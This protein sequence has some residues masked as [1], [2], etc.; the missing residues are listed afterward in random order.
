VF[1]EPCWGRTLEGLK[2]TFSSS[3]RPSTCIA[4][5]C[6]RG[7]GS[8]VAP[9]SVEK[10]GS[11]GRTRTYNPPVNSRASCMPPA[12]SKGAYSRRKASQ[13]LYLVGL[14]DHLAD[15]FP[16]LDGFTSRPFDSCSAAD[17]RSDETQ[18]PLRSLSQMERAIPHT[19]TKIH[20]ERAS[21]NAAWSFT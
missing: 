16:G 11:S 20:C 4:S 5:S 6:P 1:A 14:A 2:K 3:T 19:L 21:R 7:Q 9:L 15:K 17:R 18:Y 12:N 10:N 8:I 13:P